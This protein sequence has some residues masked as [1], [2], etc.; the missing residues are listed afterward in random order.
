MKKIIATILLCSAALS[1]TASAAD[2]INSAPTTPFYA[3]VQVGNGFTIMGG[4]KI[5]KMFA[6][7]A[8]H[9]PYG[10]YSM[11]NKCGMNN[12]VTNNY[13]YY[14]YSSFGIFGVAL[15]PLN[16]TGA[17]GLSLF[18]KVGVVSSTASYRIAGT[19]YSDNYTGLGFGGGAQ[20][21]FTKRISARVGHDFNTSY[22]NNLYNSLYVGAIFKF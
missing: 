1:A 13:D 16:L 8:N 15:F 17:P 19:N 14:N 3:G 6:V 22:A 10:S 4:V 7:E 18:A 2:Y 12:C 21:D 9:T 20:Y 5:D 11:F